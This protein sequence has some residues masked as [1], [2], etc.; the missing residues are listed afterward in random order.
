MGIQGCKLTSSK[1]TFFNLNRIS[2][3]PPIPSSTD[4]Q[5]STPNSL[6]RDGDLFGGIRHSHS[7]L[8]MSLNIILQESINKKHFY[9][10]GSLPPKSYMSLSSRSG[11]NS[12]SSKLSPGSTC[13]K[14]AGKKP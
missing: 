2:A 14:L 1:K 7:L 6:A 3:L 11:F 8:N 12:K 9:D 4:N 5:L 13:Q 10:V